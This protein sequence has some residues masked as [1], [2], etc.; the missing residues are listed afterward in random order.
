MTELLES[1]ITQL[2]TLPEDDQD[3]IATRLLAEL[4]DEQQWNQH[5]TETTDDQWDNLASI[6]RQE[7]ASM[8]VMPLDALFP[9]KP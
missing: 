6:V 2:K 7:I 8:E 4:Q 5:F 1:V 9:I 3:A